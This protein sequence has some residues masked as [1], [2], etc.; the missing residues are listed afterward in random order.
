MVR[1]S[2]GDAILNQREGEPEGFDEQDLE[3]R[4]TAA[5]AEHGAEIFEN[6]VR[7]FGEAMRDEPQ[8]V[9]EEQVT[10]AL[11]A[12]EA[13]RGESLPKF[14]AAENPFAETT[15][16]PDAANQAAVEMAEAVEAELKSALQETGEL[17]QQGKFNEA[18][19]SVQA[20]VG[21]LEQAA[22]Q[23]L[24]LETRQMLADVKANL[25]SIRETDDPA[26]KSRLYRFACGAADFIPVVGPA[27]MAAEAAY[28]QTLG[29]EELSGWGR[30]LHGT[31]GVVF[32]AVDLTGFGAVAT[33]ML[34]GGE[35]GIRLGPKLITR[36][37]AFMRTVGVSKSV[38]RPLFDVGVFVAK[39]PAVAQAATKGLLGLAAARTARRVT[40]LPNTLQSAGMAEA[41]VGEAAA[42]PGRHLE[43]EAVEAA[44]AA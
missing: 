41:A 24:P 37:A 33:K 42:R 35:V 29:G 12:E 19:D 26:A 25:A 8:P 16:R 11:M 34:K 20:V 43:A 27:K 5:F 40:E 15:F 3:E 28:G 36:T 38:Y 4:A 1:L 9:A 14:S 10:A 32:L 22:Q 13:E 21:R 6:T 23:P 2:E 7:Q 44:A 39:H 30:L 18:A 31:E 17:V